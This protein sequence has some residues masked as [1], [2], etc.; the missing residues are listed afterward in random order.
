MTVIK[1]YA[2][3]GPRNA[4]AIIQPFEW[5]YTSSGTTRM[6]DISPEAAVSCSAACIDSWLIKPGWL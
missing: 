3:G 4:C 6:D 2:N 1:G 5:L